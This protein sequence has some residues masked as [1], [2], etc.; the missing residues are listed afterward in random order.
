MVEVEALDLPAA[1]LVH[2][3][4]RPPAPG[5]DPD[6][7]WGWRW[8]Y[9]QVNRLRATRGLEPLLPSVEVSA[10]VVQ[11]SRARRVLATFP[12]ELDSW[13]SP[14]ENVVYVGPINESR[15]PAAW[16]SP[17]PDTDK[18]PL[19]VVT[20]GTMYMGQESVI[21]RVLDALVPIP[22]RV[23]VLT[24]DELEPGELTARPDV[25]VESYVSHASVFPHAR[26]V[27]MH[28]GMGTLLEC[29]R[30]GVPSI[31]IPLGRDQHGNAR[32]AAAVH[33][34]TPV[35][36]DASASEI[37]AAIRETLDSATIRDGVSSMSRAMAGYGGAVTAA[38]EIEDVC[39]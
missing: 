25:R 34:T 28:G 15:T 16:H 4:V 27:L 33:A 26:L 11:A 37:R 36:A 1:S 20:F 30:A 29:L 24:G 6:S 38:D 31:C 8:Q 23:L 12:R 3:A 19:V 10:T 35:S 13:L 14:P 18:R 7:E 5:R 21:E 17:W 22:A 32:A 9:E 39:G 2:M